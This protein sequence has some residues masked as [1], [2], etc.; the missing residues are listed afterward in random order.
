[1]LTLLSIGKY[2]LHPAR[3]AGNIGGSNRADAATAAKEEDGCDKKACANP[4]D[5]KDSFEIFTKF[6]W[7]KELSSISSLGPDIDMP[8]K[9]ASAGKASRSSVK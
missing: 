6:P 1:M 8:Q 9:Q 5:S 4:W 7:D 2:K 3:S